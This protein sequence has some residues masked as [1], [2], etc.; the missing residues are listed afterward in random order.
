MYVRERLLLLFQLFQLF[1]Q[2][3]LQFWATVLPRVGRVGLVRPVRDLAVYPLARR[4]QTQLLP[5]NLYLPAR[6]LSSHLV[7]SYLTMRVGSGLRSETKSCLFG[8]NTTG[9]R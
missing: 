9:R 5:Q 3:V 4:T 1:H 6:V 8:V 7:I 2:F